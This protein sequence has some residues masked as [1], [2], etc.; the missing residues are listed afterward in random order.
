MSRSTTRIRSIT[1][2]T[3]G[4]H[5]YEDGVA[6]GYFDYW[7]N[8][9]NYYSYDVAVV[10]LNSTNA[11]RDS[12]D[13]FA[14]L[15]ADIAANT[16]RCTLVYWHHPA[17]SIGTRGDSAQMY[18]EWAALVEAD[19]DIFMGGNDHNYQRWESLGPDG[20]LDPLGAVSFV[21]GSGGHGMR[22][23]APGES[24][25]IPGG[26]GHRSTTSQPTRPPKRSRS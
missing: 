8:I 9:P 17:W 11:F 23:F 14:W 16:A 15:R 24:E 26:S 20:E 4:N 13:Q 22:P 6:P 12:P 19:A 1:N 5:E 10:T 3:V 21:V 25:A 18:D 2:P 7:D